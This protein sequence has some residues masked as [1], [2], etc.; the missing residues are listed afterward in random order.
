MFFII[1]GIIV[2]ALIAKSA[3]HIVPSGSVGIVFR[4]GRFKSILPSGLHFG[5]PFL[6]RLFTLNPGQSGIMKSDRLCEF[7]GIQAPVVST[8]IMQAGDL[9][10]IEKIENEKIFVVAESLITK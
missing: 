3:I 10:R 7:L 4:T 1:F 6:D 9:V 5:A 8:M 2:S